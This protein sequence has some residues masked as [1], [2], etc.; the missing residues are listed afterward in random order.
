MY[1]TGNISAYVQQYLSEEG[2][3]VTDGEIFVLLPGILIIMTLLFPLCG[4]I[5]KKLDPRM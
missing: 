4:I 2:S 5:S 1:I 3:Q